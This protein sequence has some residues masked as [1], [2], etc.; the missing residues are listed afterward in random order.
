MVSPRYTIPN[1]PSSM[2]CV[3]RDYSNDLISGV[4]ASKLSFFQVIIIQSESDDQSSIKCV[5]PN[6]ENEWIPEI[7]V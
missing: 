7:V 3:T 4:H 6:T 5:P 1:D 2:T